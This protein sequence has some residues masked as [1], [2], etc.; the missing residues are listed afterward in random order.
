MKSV[1]FAALFKAFLLPFGI[2]GKVLCAAAALVFISPGFRAAW[3]AEVCHHDLKVE[4]QPKAHRLLVQDD[5]RVEEWK[6]GEISL[7]L[8]EKANIKSVLVNGKPSKYSFTSGKLSLAAIS[9][10]DDSV[11]VFFLR[12]LHDL[13]MTSPCGQPVSI[14]TPPTHLPCA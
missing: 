7:L 4:L 2:R 12:S 14:V 5:I 13:S 8:S 11:D 3:G 6:G 10:D 1:A 9:A